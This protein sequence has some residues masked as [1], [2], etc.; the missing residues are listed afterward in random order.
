MPLID[1]ECR[2]PCSLIC[3]ISN[4]P[5]LIPFR[6]L[7]AGL[8]LPPFQGNRMA[9]KCASQ[10]RRLPSHAG[11]AASSPMRT[12]RVTSMPPPAVRFALAPRAPCPVYDHD[13]YEG[14]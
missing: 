5:P 12:S 9:S 14:E 8:T 6:I 4:L 3:L 1:Q 10:A 13:E 11:T 2:R 7:W